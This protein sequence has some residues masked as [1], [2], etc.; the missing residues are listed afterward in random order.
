MHLPFSGSRTIVLNTTGMG[1]SGSVS[2]FPVL[3]RLTT[4]FESDVINGVRDGAPDVRFY[5]ATYGWLDYQIERWD[6]AGGF[7][8][9]WV[10]F[11]VVPGNGTDQFTMYYGNA[12]IADGQNPDSVFSTRTV[13][14][15]CGI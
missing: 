9:I 15:V 11:P 3:I 2:D 10:R 1:L 4:A 7:A 12:T 14:W 8:E 5:S 13:S 6:K